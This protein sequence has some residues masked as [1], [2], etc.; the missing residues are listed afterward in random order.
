MNGNEL[1]KRQGEILDKIKLYIYKNKKSPSIRDLCFL[2]GISSTA[3]MVEHLKR[4]KSKGYIS[5][6]KGEHRA[7]SVVENE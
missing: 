7:I 5:Y 6:N 4:L 3:T 1:T 2:C